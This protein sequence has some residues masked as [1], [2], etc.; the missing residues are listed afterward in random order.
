MRYLGLI[1]S[2]FIQWLQYL[3]R[4]SIPFLTY[5][6][7]C[8]AAIVPLDMGHKASHL[9]QP[10]AGYK[11]HAYSFAACRRQPAGKWITMGS[12][13]TANKCIGREIIRSDQTTF[14][15]SITKKDTRGGNLN[16]LH[17]KKNICNLDLPTLVG[18]KSNYKGK[19]RKYFV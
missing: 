6:L 8:H 2:G 17:E 12:S 16:S 1:S 5:Q 15:K 18:C 13:E 4:T 9:P 7:K 10:I 14:C 19:E 3:A 11:W